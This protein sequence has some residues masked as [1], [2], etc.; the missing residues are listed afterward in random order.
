MATFRLKNLERVPL[1][2]DIDPEKGESLHLAPREVSRELTQEE[3]QC[4]AITK[5]VTSGKARL[6]EVS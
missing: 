6:T 3:S 2:V 1:S 5:L 4:A